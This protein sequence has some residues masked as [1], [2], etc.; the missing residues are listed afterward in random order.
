MTINFN[1]VNI[2]PEQLRAQQEEAE[3]SALNAYMDLRET[4]DC[5]YA[6]INQICSPMGNSLD[7]KC[8]LDNESIFTPS[9]CKDCPA[10]NNK[11]YTTD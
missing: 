6:V 3:Q 7:V 5:N 1:G 9:R 2:D 10:Y 11:V 8:I 4:F